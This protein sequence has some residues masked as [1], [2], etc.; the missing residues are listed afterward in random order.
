MYD[1]SQKSKSYL[2]P[3]RKDVSEKE[4]TLE[5]ILR[6]YETNLQEFKDLEKPNPESKSV[7]NVAKLF[8]SSATTVRKVLKEKRLFGNVKGAPYPRD[9]L[10]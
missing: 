6:I 4:E 3:K 5:S 2:I 7:K 10:N 1:N 9:T 8:G